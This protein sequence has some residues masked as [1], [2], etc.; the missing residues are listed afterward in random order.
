MPTTWWFSVINPMGVLQHPAAKTRAG[1]PAAPSAGEFPAYPLS[2]YLLGASR[3]VRRDRPLAREIAGRR[4][5][6]FRT[7]RGTPVLLE[8][9][10]CHLGADLSLGRICGDA[11][12]CPF[13][14]WEFG[15]DGA[16]T[17]IPVRDD[18]PRWAQQTSYPVVERHGLVFFFNASEALFPLPFFFGCRPDD[19]SRARP[20]ATTL[21]CPWYLVGANAFD[22]QHFRA[23]HD[24]RLVGLPE[25]DCPA[26]F[27]RR[28][29]GTFDV[30]SDSLL[31]RLTRALAGSQVTMSITD[32]C[33]NLLFAT[34]Q[35][36]RTCSYGMVCTTPLSSGQTRV[37][38]V[39][40]VPRSA[41]LA[42]RC[43]LDPLHAEVRRL[44]IKKF[45]SADAA[46]LAGTRYSP[47]GL[48]AE[49]Q[50]LA[51]YFLWLVQSSQGNPWAGQAAPPAVQSRPLPS[52]SEVSP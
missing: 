9:R 50:H 34:A 47:S 15:P 18:I 10:C 32:Y 39:V 21:D 37:A 45:L 49:D 8:S 6:A 51:D 12:Q 31:D 40:F 26:P 14:H 28:A 29:T 7:S 43:L 24:R 52:V 13:H 11:I 42:G 46:R 27:A 3:E 41:S 36:R 35:F 44:F 2:W 16:C 30:A 4:L 25:V 23:A 1:A 48:I 19:F 5:V 20:F 38:V 33:G 17:K 22:L